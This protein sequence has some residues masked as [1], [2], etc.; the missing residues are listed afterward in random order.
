MPKSVPYH[1]LK[2]KSLKDP[3]FAAGLPHRDT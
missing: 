3:L 2:F 1:P